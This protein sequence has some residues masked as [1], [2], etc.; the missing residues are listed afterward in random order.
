MR[1]PIYQFTLGQNQ[2]GDFGLL[3][4][5]EIEENSSQS[6]L[7]AIPIID[8]FQDPFHFIQN[9]SEV[10]FYFPF[11][12]DEEYYELEGKVNFPEITFEVP[13]TEYRIVFEI[14]DRVYRWPPFYFFEKKIYPYQKYVGK[15]NAFLGNTN[16]FLF[17]E[18]TDI[19]EMDDLYFEHK[20]VFIGLTPN[21]GKN[22]SF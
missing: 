8:K 17:L 14:E 4:P 21:F 7:Y 22:V 1:I 6:I 2:Q 20:G 3:F 13:N 10:Q 11:L 19:F 5:L 16:G 15:F 12:L 18:P 9:L